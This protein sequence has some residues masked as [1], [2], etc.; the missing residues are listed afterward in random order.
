ME[1]TVSNRVYVVSVHRPRSPKT[2]RRGFSIKIEDWFEGPVMEVWSWANEYIT[3]RVMKSYGKAISS[4]KSSI[5]IAVL[6]AIAGDQLKRLQAAEKAMITRR[7]REAGKKAAAT[8]KK[9][10]EL[11]GLM[12][13]R[14]DLIVNKK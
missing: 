6:R 12:V 4:K 8:R 7:R 2:G 11:M 13:P 9:K 5:K 1:N 3:N 10:R 14:Y